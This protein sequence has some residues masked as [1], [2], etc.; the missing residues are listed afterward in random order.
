MGAIGGTIG[1]REP[2]S[3]CEGIFCVDA[4][5]FVHTRALAVFLWV[6]MVSIAETGGICFNGVVALSIFGLLDLKL[7]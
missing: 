4:E 6:P 2:F 5:A 7:H 1:S 3:R